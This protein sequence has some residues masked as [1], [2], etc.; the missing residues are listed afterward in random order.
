MGEN[1]DIRLARKNG[2]PIA[3]ILSLRHRSYTVYKYGCSD[4][5][6]HNLGGM[7][8]LFW[9]LIEESKVSGM[10]KIDFGRSDVDQEGL[11]VFKDRLGTRKKLAAYY[12]Y[13]NAIGRR[14]PVPWESIWLRKLFSSLPDALM[15]AAGRIMYKHMG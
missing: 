6:L 7:P 2:T 14:E 9:R 11:I 15:S 13:T 8:F 4:A 12:R 1:I 3:A 5:K 10:E